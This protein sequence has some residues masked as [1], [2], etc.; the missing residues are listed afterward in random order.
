MLD[1]AR[2]IISGSS[3]STHP[4]HTLSEHTIL[5]KRLALHNQ[6]GRYTWLRLLGEAREAA[7]GS[8]FY[9]PAAPAVLFS[10]LL[11]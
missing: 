7:G 11:L 6:P 2:P 3:A 4:G 1:V 5:A 10:L 9:G 8:A